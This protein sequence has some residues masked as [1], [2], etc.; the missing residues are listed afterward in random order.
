MV[1]CSAVGLGRGCREL[2]LLGSDGSIHLDGDVQA[3]QAGAR[4]MRLGDTEPAEIPPDPRLPGSGVELPQRRARWAILALALMLEDWLPA[5][6][7]D[8]APGVPTLR[9]GWRTQCVI[10]A[11]RRSAA[12]EGWVTLADA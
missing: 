10:D 5:F 11:A 6:G 7:G 4:G 2:E 1:S 12:G 9:D 3:Q 8:V